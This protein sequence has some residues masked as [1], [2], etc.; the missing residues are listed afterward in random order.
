MDSLPPVDPLL[1]A[2]LKTRVSQKL[3]S[4]LQDLPHS[5]IEPRLMTVFHYSHVCQSSEKVR[6]A[7]LYEL[8]VQELKKEN[9]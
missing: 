8:V 3:Q 5:I 6:N 4:L 1:E 9:E 2:S 7:I